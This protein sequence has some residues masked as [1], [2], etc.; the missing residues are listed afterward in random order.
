[1]L[2]LDRLRS[3]HYPL[4]LTACQ[5]SLDALPR[6]K[7]RLI[8]HPPESTYDAIVA[9]K[10]VHDADRPTRRELGALLGLSTSMVHFYL[11]RL[12]QAGLLE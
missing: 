4:R 2:S 1:M 3:P 11:K 12:V 8:R 7:P 10:A 9:H 6:R 5:P